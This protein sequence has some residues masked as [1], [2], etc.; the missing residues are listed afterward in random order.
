MSEMEISCICLNG[1]KCTTY[2]VE[3]AVNVFTTFVYDVFYNL[4]YFR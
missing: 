4:T 3:C 2:F 1:K